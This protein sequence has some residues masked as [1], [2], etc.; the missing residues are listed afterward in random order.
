MHNHAPRTDIRTSRRRH[1]VVYPAI[2]LL[3]MT[4]FTACSSSNT[5]SQSTS[6]ASGKDDLIAQVASYDLAADRPQ[7]FM[8]GLQTADNSLV[9]F[10]TARFVFTFNGTGG[11]GGT[12][13]PGPTAEGTWIPV[14]GQKVQTRP[15]PAIVSSSDG[16]GVYEAKN[17][18]FGKA[19]FWTVTTTVTVDGKKRAADASFEVLAKHQV[20]TVGDDAPPSVNRLAGDTSVKATAIDSRAGTTDNVP[21]PLLHAITVADAIRTGRPTVIVISTPTYCVSKFCGP[22]TDSVATLAAANKNR[23]NFVHLEVWSNFENTQLNKSA[24]DWIYREGAEDAHEPWVFL[25]GADGKIL[26]R[27]DN[28]TSDESLSTALKEST[29]G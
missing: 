16:I 26:Q 20:P 7:R 5:G 2:A 17:V 12:P 27:W 3:A 1:C 22:I 11:G 21:D 14:A 10:G 19:G 18:N 24:A 4:M 6:T 8:I 15:S 28:V 29:G 23:A 13:E 25:V 9:D